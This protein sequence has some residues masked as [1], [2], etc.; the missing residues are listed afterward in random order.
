M[1]DTLGSAGG[2]GAFVTVGTSF[3]ST[4]DF[5]K[6][7]RQFSPRKFDPVVRTHHMRVVY[8]DY[9]GGRFLV[10][11]D[12][13]KVFQ[14]TDLGKTWTLSPMNG[15]GEWT[16]GLRKGMAYGNGAFV[17]KADCYSRNSPL[18]NVFA[19]WFVFET[20]MEP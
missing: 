6:T 20:S 8:G 4:P 12:G 3:E 14:S 19:V 18:G 16:E 11:G 1:N 13:P 17:M 10:M 5:G 15:W 7:W 9:D 2:Q